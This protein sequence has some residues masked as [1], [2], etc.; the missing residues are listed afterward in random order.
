MIPVITQIE[1]HAEVEVRFPNVEYFTNDSGSVIAV[2]CMQEVGRYD[3]PGIEGPFYAY[4]RATALD[5]D[6][7]LMYDRVEWY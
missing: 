2:D 4:V 5:N 1:W 3:L 6:S 7:T